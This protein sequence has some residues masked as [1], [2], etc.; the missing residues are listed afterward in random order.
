MDHLIELLREEP[1]L[2]GA[3][4]DCVA[5]FDLTDAP[6]VRDRVIDEVI[7][8]VSHSTLPS[9]ILCPFLYH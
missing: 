4:L 7:G 9:Y 8:T 5:A 3:I 2:V 1:G 6:T